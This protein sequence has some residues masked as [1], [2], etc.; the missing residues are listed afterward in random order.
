MLDVGCRNRLRCNTD[1]PK[2][3]TDLAG[4][5]F[6]YLIHTSLDIDIGIES[7]TTPRNKK[8]NRYDFDIQ[9][10]RW[11]LESKSDKLKKIKRA[12]SCCTHRPKLSFIV[13]IIKRRGG[14]GGQNTLE[15]IKFSIHRKIEKIGTMSNYYPAFT[16]ASY[17]NRGSARFGPPKKSSTDGT[18]LIML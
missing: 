1:K 14:G 8:T 5:R 2:K 11:N 12:N 4:I 16:G 3:L 17:D 7:D 15:K 9:Y 13:N 10:H 18:P 6:W